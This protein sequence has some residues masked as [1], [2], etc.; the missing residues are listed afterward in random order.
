MT[1]GIIPESDREGRAVSLSVLAPRRQTQC[2]SHRKSV[3]RE[4]PWGHP[5]PPFLLGKEG[6]YKVPQKTA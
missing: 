1:V 6:N 3:R 4:S 2:D 5:D